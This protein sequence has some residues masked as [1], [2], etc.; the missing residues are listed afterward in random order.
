MLSVTD[1]RSLATMGAPSLVSSS[2][3]EQIVAAPAE[4]TDYL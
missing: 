1:E 4:G 3:Q 2:Q